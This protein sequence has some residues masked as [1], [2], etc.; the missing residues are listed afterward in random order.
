ME[1]ADTCIRVR[2]PAAAFAV[3][4]AAALALSATAPML[5]M[6]W[7]EGDSL[8]RAGQ[9]SQGR[10]EFTVEREGHPAGFGIVIAA[11]WRLAAGWLPPLTAARFGPMLLFAAAAGAL[12]YRLAKDHSLTAGLGGAAAMLLLPRMFAHAHVAASDGPLTACWVLAWAVFAPARQGWKWALLWGGLLGATLSMKATGWL[13]PVPFVLWAALYRDRAALRAL[14]IGLPVALVVFFLMNPPL[15]QQPVD[16]W[17]TFFRLNFGR[18]GGGLNISTWFLG[19]MYNLDHALPWYN[20]LVWTA[21]TVPPGL[22]LLAATGTVA[23]LRRPGRR[24]ADVLILLNGLVL[25]VVRTLPGVPVHDGVRLFLP[26]FA[27][28]AAMAGIGAH[29]VY[30]WA[31]RRWPARRR[32]RVLWI[33]GLV[34]VYAACSVNLWL[35][36][37]QWLSYYSPAIGGL[38]GAAA[39]GMEPTY[40]WDALDA[41]AIEWLHANTPAGEKIRFAAPSPDNLVWMNQWGVLRRGW[42]EAQPGR[43]RWYVVQHRPSAWQPP[44]RWLLENATPVY[45]K[46]LLGVPLLSVYRYDEFVNV[47]RRT[48]NAER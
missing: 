10:W 4:L 30:G 7:D 18:A 42:H 21:V 47:E 27:F 20:T 25:L 12:F 11:G 41:D 16:G 35:Y 8:R 24:S 34:G 31:A 38:P 40:W 37:P 23:A 1:R 2:L 6:T 46:T 28:V 5:P 3:A 22:L 39:A 15:W 43:Y 44:D 26:S 19:R 13:A 32:P 36:A 48:S 17:A 9:I 45:R 33:G 14:G 29:E